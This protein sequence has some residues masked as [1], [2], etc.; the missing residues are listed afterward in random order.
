M[1][2]KL[3]NSTDSGRP[4]AM[5]WYQVFLF[6][7]GMIVVK[8]FRSFPPAAAKLSTRVVRGGG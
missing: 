7:T 6:I 1:G 8:L 3:A 4:E 5:L 2:H